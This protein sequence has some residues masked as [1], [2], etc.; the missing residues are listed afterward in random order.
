MKKTTLAILF[1]AALFLGSSDAF[2]QGKWAP[3]VPNA[4]SICLITRKTT[5]IRHTTTL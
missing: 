4:S 3:T 2:A 1:G 5:R